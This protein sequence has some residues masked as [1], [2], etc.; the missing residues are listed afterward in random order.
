MRKSDS[1]FF[2]TGPGE[3][4]EGDSFIGVRVPAIRGVARKYGGLSVTDL[5]ILFRSEIHEERLL[6]LIILTEK[7]RKGTNGERA[8]IYKLY[9]NS[10]RYI[11]NWDL[12][13]T[14]AEHIVGA[15]LKSR[16]RNPL[17]ELAQSENL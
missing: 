13:D 8:R 10:T 11:N 5:K 14:S 16:S 4:G 15:F 7:Y 17:Y 6:A 12:V 3:Y 9:L 2:K 1:D